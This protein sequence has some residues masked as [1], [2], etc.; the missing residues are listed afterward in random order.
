MGME[1]KENTPSEKTK[2]SEKESRV[3]AKTATV[4]ADC[5]AEKRGMHAQSRKAF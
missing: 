4:E 1:E 2:Q 5:K 3:S